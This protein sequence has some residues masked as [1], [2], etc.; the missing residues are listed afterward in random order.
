M[1]GTRSELGREGTYKFNFVSLVQY[2]ILPVELAYW[3]LANEMHN[4]YG[5]LTE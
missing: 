4:C 2:I 1:M 3:L 5:Y